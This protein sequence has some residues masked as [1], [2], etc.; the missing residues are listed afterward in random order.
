MEVVFRSR[1]AADSHMQRHL[2]SGSARVE[3]QSIRFVVDLGLQEYCWL[4]AVCELGRLM[5]LAVRM[6]RY[7]LK[8]LLLASPLHLEAK[9]A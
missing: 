5:R 2:V 1:L 7:Y 9:L 3:E 4:G 8:A 6:E